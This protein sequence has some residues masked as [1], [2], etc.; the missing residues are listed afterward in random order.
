MLD[1]VSDIELVGD[2]VNGTTGQWGVK[3]AVKDGDNADEDDEAFF[4]LP[5]VLIT[6]RR[7]GVMVLVYNNSQ[8][9]S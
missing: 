6:R 3:G 4:S 5:L 1:G 2:K 9:T 7:L 8:K